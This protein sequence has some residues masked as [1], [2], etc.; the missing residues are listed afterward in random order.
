[1]A[2]IIQFPEGPAAHVTARPARQGRDDRPGHGYSPAAGG[3]REDGEE[4]EGSRS[5]GEGIVGFFLQR[6]QSYNAF[7]CSHVMT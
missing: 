6:N 7:W 5:E 3:R 1:M 4:G 2:F